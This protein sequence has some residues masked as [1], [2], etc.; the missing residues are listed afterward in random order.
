M[1]LDR[2]RIC[3]SSELLQ[4]L[5]LGEMAFTGVFPRKRDDAMPSGRLSLVEC[6]TC[7]LVQLDRHFDLDFLFGPTYGYRSGLNKGM[8]DHLYEVCAQIRELVSLKQGDV[9]VDIGSSDGTLLKAMAQL[10]HGTIGIGFDPQGARYQE[11]YPPGAAVITEF[12]TSKK[13]LETSSI[14]AKVITSIA[15]FYDLLDPLAFA[16]DIAAALA[17]DGV[18]FMEQA[19]LP[20]MIEATGFDTICHE[21]LEFYGLEQIRVIA[22]MAGLKIVDFGFNKVHGGSFWV[23]LAHLESLY[24]VSEKL[25]GAVGGER[26]MLSE[27]AWRRFETRIADTKK[28]TLEFLEMARREKKRVLGLGASTKGNVLLQAFGIDASHLAAISD[29]NEDKWG[30]FTPHPDPAKRIP[31]VSEADARAMKPDYF[32]VLPWHF[33]EGIIKREEDFLQN[34]GGL[35][36]P[37]PKFRIHQAADAGLRETA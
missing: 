23:V 1:L 11:M 21:H 8:V 17:R 32:L 27:L 20:A 9:V 14:K 25:T 19:Y 5:D 4:R 13:F 10:R 2:C 37:L 22:K 33:A 3:R 26:T 15:M 6:Q 31:I 34:G 35:V 29:V 24:S 16:Q 7:G 18:W 36:F 28:A 12:F 30:S